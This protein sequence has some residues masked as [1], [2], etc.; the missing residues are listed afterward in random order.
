MRAYI[1]RRQRGC[2]FLYRHPRRHLPPGLYIGRGTCLEQRIHP[3]EQVFSWFIFRLS[4]T[5]ARIYSHSRAYILR[6]STWRRAYI[7]CGTLFSLSRLSAHLTWTFLPSLC[8]QGT[9]THLLCMDYADWLPTVPHKPAP[10][11]MYL[12]PVRC[13][14]VL[15]QLHNFYWTVFIFSNPYPQI[16]L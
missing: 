1:H 9:A 6:I 16:Y 13:D 10:C 5:L 2:S 3:R 14:I 12:R 15:P 8:V 4:A 7:H 11:P